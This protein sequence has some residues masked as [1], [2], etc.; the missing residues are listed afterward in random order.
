MVF[1][2]GIYFV[3][4]KPSSASSVLFSDRRPAPCPDGPSPLARVCISW[5][6]MTCLGAKNR[7][8]LLLCV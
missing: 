4:S 5:F 8:L 1:L 7:G 2:C 3:S 6:C